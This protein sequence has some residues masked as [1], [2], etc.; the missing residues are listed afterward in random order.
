M[1][2]Q[3]GRPEF[4]HADG[5]IGGYPLNKRYFVCNELGYLVD[6]VPF[7]VISDAERHKN[8]LDAP[9]LFS[10]EQWWCVGLVPVGSV[11]GKRNLWH[12]GLC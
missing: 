5:T 10:V 7:K 6:R 8:S 12:A 3:D 11:D 9:E 4:D 1:K 2:F